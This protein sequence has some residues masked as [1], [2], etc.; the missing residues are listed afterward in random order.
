MKRA[1][2]LSG[3]GAKGAYQLGVYK[4]LKRL[5]IKINIITGTSIGAINGALLV[6]GDYRK[7]KK[8]WISTKTSNVLHH[9]ISN[10][11]EYADILKEYV[12]NKGLKFD[13]AEEYIGK[14][15]KE[16]KVRK[17]KTDYGLVTVNLK[18]RVP[19]M[20]SKDQIPNGK[21]ISYISASA[22]CFPAVEKKEIDGEYYI[23]GGYYDNLPINLAIDMGADE[24]IAVD[25]S[26]L[27]I[28]Q[29]VKNKSIKI[30][31]I[32]SNNKKR[33]SLNFSPMNSKKSISLG[34]NDTMKH[35]SM[36]DG[37]IYTFNKG[38]LERN[39]NKISSN[40]INLIKLIL[41]SDK[42]KF[43]AIDIL[44]NKRY[45]DMFL[46]IKQ[47]KMLDVEINNALE[48]LALLFGFDDDRIYS[49]NLFNKMLV[50]EAKSLDY[51]TL[52]KKLK[53]KMLVGYIYN[54]YMNESDNE[55]AIKKLFNISLIFQKDFM[56]A[57]YLIA[58]SSTKPIE[59]CNFSD[60]I[61][62]KFKN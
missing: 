23:D 51:I 39:Y 41:L 59:S 44:K 10:P 1:L 61:L 35:F 16:S 20:L 47:G 54:K 42:K 31:Y 14:I 55:E 46:K 56:A 45:Q 57:L 27:G 3:G 4:A 36:L 58:I 60:E 17:S 21:L 2:V 33:F 50:R 62:E 19:K 9:D 40:Y 38:D 26:A 7:A 6:S 52:D 34:F 15:I 43:A 24:I 5:G 29:K 22:A 37:N 28:K 18:T 49:I 13:K 11:K 48:Y 32:K 8:L 12:T 30:D 25:L 53:G